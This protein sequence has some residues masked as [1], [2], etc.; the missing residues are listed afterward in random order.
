MPNEEKF[1]E[2]I[3]EVKTSRNTISYMEDRI[4]TKSAAQCTQIHAQ[5]FKSNDFNEA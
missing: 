2:I 3:A 1:F 4:R 5:L